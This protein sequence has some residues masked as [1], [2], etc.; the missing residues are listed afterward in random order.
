MSR[1]GQ[2]RVHPPGILER[3]A[4]RIRG[5]E[6]LLVRG[7][8]DRPLLLV[9]YPRGNS[10]IAEEVEAAYAHTLRRMSS[11]VLGPYE[12]VFPVLPTLVVVLLRARN[13]CSCL[14]HHH[15]AG[16]ES[17]QTRRLAADIGRAVAEIDLAYEGIRE[18]Q[19]QPLSSLA[20]GDLGGRLG[21]LH[22]QAAV[23]AVL[24]HELEHLAFPEHT[25]HEIRLRS[26]AFYAAAM[27]QLVKEETNS[28]YG[29]AAPSPRP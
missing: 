5:R 9:S 22:F 10:E 26:N 17:R 29:M 18:W 6:Q 11:E 3:L 15:P 7:G 25:E 2:H 24:L 23:L 1:R 4:D 12:P 16:T 13:P 27:E 14:G 19:P 8:E 28:G 21:A 20:V